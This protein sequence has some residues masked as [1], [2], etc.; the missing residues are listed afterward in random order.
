MAVV[1][2]GAF[3][4]AVVEAADLSRSG[5]LTEIGEVFERGGSAFSGAGVGFVSFSGTFAVRGGITASTGV[6]GITA[7]ESFSFSERGAVAGCFSCTAWGRAGGVAGSFGVATG[8][9]TLVAAGFG[10]TTTG[11]STADGSACVS[12]SL[13]SV[14][15]GRTGGLSAGLA[16]AAGEGGVTGAEGEMTSG[17]VFLSQSVAV[18]ARDEA[19]GC[20]GLA[21]VD[22]DCVNAGTF[23]TT[24]GTARGAGSVFFGASAGGIGGGNFAG[25]DSDV[26]S[27]MGGATCIGAMVGG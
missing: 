8:A 6:A 22:S 17:V 23:K 1:T 19:G 25:A 9:S 18:L 4:L 7:A 16:S 24:G 27:S 10:T 26:L 11:G 20:N 21:G 14:R 12:A 15:L 5:N 3:N 13:S 2:P